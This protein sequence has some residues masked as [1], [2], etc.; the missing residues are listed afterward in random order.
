[1]QGPERLAGLDAVV[2]A[3]QAGE[4][5]VGGQRLGL[6]AAA[7][8][9]QHE[10]KTQPLPDREL[11]DQLDQPAHRLAVPAGG[12]FQLGT[13]LQRDGPQL[14]QPVP[15]GVE[16]EAG[17]PGERLALPQLQR[18]VRLGQR[19]PG[20]PGRLRLPGVPHAPLETRHVDRLGGHPQQVTGVGE[21]EHLGRRTR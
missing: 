15:G 13:R 1:M 9:R 17:E 11:G 19:H 7:V 21:R 4:V 14:D 16:P 8:E 18:G 10:L 3:Q 12:K 2:V 20:L 6:P 5:P